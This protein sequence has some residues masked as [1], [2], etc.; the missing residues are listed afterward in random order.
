MLPSLDGSLYSTRVVDA[1]G[2][3]ALDRH[4]QSYAGFHVLG[5]GRPGD[6]N[7]Q[8]GVRVE[9]VDQAPDGS[10]GAVRVSNVGIDYH[11]SA[12]RD[13]VWPGAVRRLDGRIVNRGGAARAISVTMEA[14]HGGRR[15]FE[16]SSDAPVTVAPGAEATK[17][18]DLEIPVDAALTPGSTVDVIARFTE[19]DDVWERRLALKVVARPRIF[20]PWLNRP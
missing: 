9:L 19:G 12:S 18:H 11:L 20:L 1:D 17:S 2:K 4:G 10:W 3:P 13:T 7:L 15:I 6:A 5:T 16:A 8:H 14:W